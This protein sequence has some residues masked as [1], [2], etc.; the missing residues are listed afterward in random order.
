MDELTNETPEQ[1]NEAATAPR[2]RRGVFIS[3]TTAVS[4]FVLVLAST[5][6]GIYI[7]HDVFKPHAKPSPSA[8]SGS[9]SPFGNF[10]NFQPSAP[11]PSQ[12]PANTK[13]SAAAAKIAKSVDPGLVDI[14]TNLSYQGAAAAGTG[15]ILTSNGLV[16]TNNHVIDGATS[17]TARDIATKQVYTATVVGYDATRDVALIKLKDASGLKTVSIGNSNKLSVGEKIVGIGNAGGVGGT[18]SNAAGKIVALNQTITASDDGGGTNAEQLTGTIEINA[19]IQPGDSGGPLVTS[20]GK[21]VGMDTAASADNEAFGFS[22]TEAATKGYAI[23]I[24]SVIDLAKSI[25]AGASTTKVHV[26]KTAFLGVEV[27]TASQ[28]RDSG[29]SF[30]SSG[31]GAV[32]VQV[33]HNTPAFQSSLVAGDTIT[34]VNGETITSPSDL[35]GIMQTL[36]PGSTASVGYNEA[37]G[38]QATTS[39]QLASGPP[40]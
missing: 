4:V 15:M 29:T 24:A 21:V 1:A 9:N 18:P 27:E 25:E 3:I 11:T 20:K 31:P 30:G 26:G 37:N 10:G 14:D 39:I 35:A 19:D 12:S 8:S 6:F 17:I 33:L 38:T 23:P 13:A 34:T 5:S 2:Q 28:A 16:L 32:V 36:S 40:Q 22:Q 7:G